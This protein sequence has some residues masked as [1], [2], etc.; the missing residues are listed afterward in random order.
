MKLLFIPLSYAKSC[1]DDQATATGKIHLN[2]R[3]S[4][5]QIIPE[6]IR[7]HACTLYFF[8]NRQMVFLGSSNNKPVRY[9]QVLGFVFFFFSRYPRIYLFFIR[10]FF[11]STGVCVVDRFK[12]VRSL[13][14]A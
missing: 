8:I 13:P 6:P 1:S 11:L 4:L 5:F 7:T 10:L 3:I 9:A 2:P 14:I 12:L